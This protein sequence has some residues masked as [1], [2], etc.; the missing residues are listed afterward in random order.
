MPRRTTP[1]VRIQNSAPGVEFWTSSARR[2]G[3][4]SPPAPA[5][6][7]GAQCCAKR[8]LPAAM[9]LG[10]FSKGLRL[11]RAFGGALESSLEMEESLRG[12]DGAALFCG[13]RASNTPSSVMLAARAARRG[14]IGGGQKGGR[15]SRRTRKIHAK[16]PTAEEI[17]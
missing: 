5:P 11:E 16:R 2:L 17:G 13:P 7:H 10:S 3:P 6:W 12:V 8:F 4:F 1:F 9:A 14:F 15:C